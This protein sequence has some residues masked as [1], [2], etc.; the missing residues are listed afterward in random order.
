MKRWQK[1]LAFLAISAPLIIIFYLNLAEYQWDETYKS[2]FCSEVGGIFD[3][4]G[5]RKSYVCAMEP[6]FAALITLLISG[7]VLYAA[8][9][10][11]YGKPRRRRIK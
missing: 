4:D 3:A 9:E 5:A 6:F 2:P 8:Y 1:A 11:S 10:I 7:I